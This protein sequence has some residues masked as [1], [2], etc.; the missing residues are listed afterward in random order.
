MTGC[1]AC[2]NPVYCSQCKLGFILSGTGSAAK[3]QKCASQCTT[4]FESPNNCD[5]CASGF[6]K[7][8]WSCVSNTNVQMTLVL[9][10]VFSALTTDQYESIE[11][12]IATRLN[13]D[14]SQITV[15]EL[16]ESSIL[17]D[18]TI[19]ADNAA[20]QS[21]LMNT[22]Q[23]SLASG[24]SIGGFTVESAG[25]VSNSD[26]SDVS[27]VIA[28]KDDSEAIKY[29]NIAIIVGI[30]IP[31]GLSNYL[32]NFSHYF[33]RADHIVQEGNHLQFIK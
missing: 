31:I 3:C 2:D 26:V 22:L 29:R 10:G 25:F 7:K 23:T 32:I 5:L 20:Q 17:I 6:T 18:A 13:K 28:A 21:E 33:Y 4:C 9:N 27:D 14:R 15:N 11:E 16:R 8:G 19:D 30:V 1:V 12:G 24:A